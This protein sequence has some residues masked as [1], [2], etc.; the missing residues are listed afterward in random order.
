MYSKRNLL[1]SDVLLIV[2]LAVFGR[3]NT[4]SPF[5]TSAQGS[6]KLGDMRVKEP[7]GVPNR[8]NTNFVLPVFMPLCGN[9]RIDTKKDYADYYM[10][11]SN[12]PW[13]QTKRMILYMYRNVWKDPDQMHSVSFSADEE[14]DDGNREDFDGCSADCMSLDLW[15]SPCEIAV[16]QNLEYEDI[17]YDSVRKSVVVSARTG[18]YTLDAEFDST[19]LKASLIAGKTFKVT[20]IFRDSASLI[21][22]SAETQALYSIADGTSSITLLNELQHLVKWDPS[23]SIRHIH[24]NSDGSVVAYDADGM[25]YLST[26][27]STVYN[28][29]LFGRKISACTFSQMFSDGSA[30]FLC[31]IIRVAIGPGICNVFTS[32]AIPSDGSIWRDVF[33]KISYETMTMQMD[34]VSSF[35]IAPPIESSPS[36]ELT[37]KMYHPMG[38]FLEG[39]VGNA[40]RFGDASTNPGILYYTGDRTMLDMIIN[41]EDQKTCGPGRCIFDIDRGYDIFDRDPFKRAVGETWNDVLQEKIR[42]EAATA[43]AL[44]TLAGIKANPQRYDRLLDSFAAAFRPAVAPLVALAIM[45]HPVTRNTWALRKDRL[46]EIS[47]SGVQLMRPDGKCLPSGVALCPPCQW[48]PNGEQCRPCSTADAMSWSWNMKCKTCAPASRR[49]LE[50]SVIR[51]ALKGDFAAVNAVWYQAVSDSSIISNSSI[52]TVAIHT[53]DA[54]AEMRRIQDHLLEM[55]SVEVVTKPYVV[56]YVAMPPSPD[57]GDATTNTGVIIAAVLIPCCFLVVAMVVYVGWYAPKKSLGTAYAPVRHQYG[58]RLP[59]R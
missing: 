44:S 25:I 19:S 8:Y 9:G 56:I 2:L 23:Q 46:I 17:I 45:K 43:P 12:Q 28:P 40:R 55:T 18:I 48:A 24:Q 51:F 36:P 39:T 27:T 16:D 38:G 7:L 52:M 26:L 47:K 10:N 21:L 13:M 57:N 14:C 30:I 22:Y 6:L 49:L 37:F 11:P 41:Q 58:V 34:T 32:P 53:P 33:S 29:C 1:S 31:D 50:D 54:V 5:W 4:Q 20:D 15:T 42:Q 59:R 3:C 35:T